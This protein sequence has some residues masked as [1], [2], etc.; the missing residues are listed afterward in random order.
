M[1]IKELR[2]Q[3]D[4]LVKARKALAE[5][6]D[7]ND[8]DQTSFD[9]MASQIAALDKRITR[10]EDAYSDAGS[11]DDA[12]K[13]DDED[14]DKG[15][16]P[17]F[18]KSVAATARKAMVA[19]KGADGAGRYMIGLAVARQHGAAAGA[20]F[21]E[22]VWGDNQVSKALV[23]GTNSAGGFTIP[24]VLSTDVIEQ[25]NA[26]VAVRA[27][28]PTPVGLDAGNLNFGRQTAGAT[29]TWGNEY[30]D[31]SASQQTFDQVTLTAKKLTSLVPVSNS[32]LRRSPVGIDSIVSND[33]VT[34]LALAQDAAFIRGNTGGSNPVGLRY[35]PGITLTA[36]ATGVTLDIVSRYL[37]GMLA[38][39]E[40]NNVAITRPAWFMHPRV[41]AF[42]AM[43]R[44]GV[45]GFPFASVDA[46][47]PTL[48]GMPIFTTTQIPVNLTAI[49]G[50]ANTNGTE[51]FLAEM[52]EV[53][54]GDA[55][56]ITIDVSTEAA[57]TES[58]TLV[59]AFGRDATVF[60]AIA[61][62]DLALRHGPCVTVG[63]A[64][65]WSV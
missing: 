31:T 15:A 27:A 7:F 58:A 30:T 34:R 11:S 40:A 59:S 36:D 33:L 49:N 32:L 1:L 63:R 18:R 6:E 57:Y 29:A 26:R 24:Q 52:T 44:D 64:D 56:E 50:G 35:Q 46:P 3:K 28:G 16:K 2:R 8:E 37:R 5:K 51:I 39:L 21:V 41:K 9:D 48:M 54:L 55:V 14:E 43:L 45:G 13:D 19:R 10:L 62:C 53:M 4:A 42:I 60:R 65:S 20:D 47:S 22:R 38:S 23:A 17:G 61:E 25:L 12:D